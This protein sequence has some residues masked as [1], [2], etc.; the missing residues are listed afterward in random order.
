M[1]NRQRKLRGLLVDQ[2]GSW[3]RWLYVDGVDEALKARHLALVTDIRWIRQVLAWEG[4]ADIRADLRRQM[5]VLLAE[6]REVR[7]ELRQNI[8]EQHSSW[9]DRAAWAECTRQCWSANDNGFMGCDCRCLGE[10]HGLL[11][12][13]VTTTEEAGV[14]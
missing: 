14:R 1:N 4:A 13:V 12:L 7:T 11:Q 3:L 9:L 2:P 8:R 6:I 10:F 5:K